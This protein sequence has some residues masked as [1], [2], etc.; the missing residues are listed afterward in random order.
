MAMGALSG[1]NVEGEIRR[2][3]VEDDLVYGI[4]ACPP[5]L[6]YN[7]PLAVSLWFVR[8]MKP[9]SMKRKVLFIYAKKLFKQ[10]SR[11]QVILTEEHI[12]KIVEKFRMFEAGEPE[13]KINEVGFAKVATIE[14]IGKNGYALTPGRYVGIKEDEDE[15]PFEGKMR[16]YSEELASLLREEE[17]LTNKIKEVFNALGF[18]V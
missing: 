4:V 1:G 6:F 5:K 8:K 10:I 7:V 3:I 15:V 2:K 12:A 13:D 11:R 14:E 18:S 9:E 17:E 16:S